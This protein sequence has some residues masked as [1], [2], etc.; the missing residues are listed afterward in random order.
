LENDGGGERRFLVLPH[1]KIEVQD[2]GLLELPLSGPFGKFPDPSVCSSD[3]G[4]DLGRSFFDCGNA[5]A[6]GAC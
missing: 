5:S 2:I 3:A 4:G 1:L 6:L